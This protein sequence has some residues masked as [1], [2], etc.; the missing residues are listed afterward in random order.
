[1]TILSDLSARVQG[2]LAPLAG[3]AVY[4]VAETVQAKAAGA[5]PA[6]ATTMTLTGGP[7]I[8]GDT[9]TA[10]GLGTRTISA[11]EGTGVLFSPATTAPIAAGA[12]VTLARV[13]AW[14]VRA[15]VEGL[16]VARVANTLIAATDTTL[17]VLAEGLP[18]TPAAGHRVVIGGS[19]YVVKS[20]ASDAIGAVWRI[21]AGR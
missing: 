12:S 1:M 6:G 5:V 7:A 11:V 2:A 10:G 16:D 19:R 21:V 14:P 18:V 4:E 13:Q 15:W 9:F 3:S 8:P 17:C 20:A